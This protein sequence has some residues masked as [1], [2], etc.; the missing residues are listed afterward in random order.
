[1]RPKD[2]SHYATAAAASTAAAAAAVHVRCSKLLVWL[3]F[4]LRVGKQDFRASTKINVSLKFMQCRA[5]F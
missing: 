3:F 1:M 2:K 5:T 4:S